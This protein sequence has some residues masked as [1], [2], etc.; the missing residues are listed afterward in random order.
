MINKLQAVILI[1]FLNFTVAHAQF[2]VR[3]YGAKGDGINLDTRSFQAAVDKAFNNGGGTVEVSPGTYLTGTVVLKDNVSVH[4]QPGS[5]ILGSA[6]YTDYT[7]IIHKYDSRTNGLYAKYFMFFAEGASNISITGEGIINGNGLKNFQK[8]DPQNLRPFMIRL[9]NCRDITIRDVKLLESANWTLHLLGCR[10]VNIEGIEINAGTRSNRDGIDIDACDRV[11]VSNCRITTGDDAIVMKTTNDTICQNIAITNCIISTQ[12]SGIKTGTESNGG[13][14]NITVSNCV[15]RDIPVHT[16]IELITVDGGSMQNILLENIT[17]ENVATPFFIRLGNRARPYKAGQY[18]TGV[19]DVS[20]IMLNNITVINSKLPSGIMGLHS[21]KLRN[22][23]VNNFTV[24]SSVAQKPVNY[25]EVPFEEFSYPAA[26]VFKNLPAYGLYCRNV[27][28]LQLNNIYFYSAENETR[29]ALVLD[30]V[31]NPGMFSVKG[32]VRD[33]E[34]PLAYFRYVA[35]AEINF[36]RSIGNSNSLFKKEENN[37]ENLALL[38]NTLNTGQKEIEVVPSPGKDSLFEDFPT[39]LKYI[40]S[41]SKAFKGLP[42]RDLQEEPLKFSMEINKRG[43]LQLC[44]LILDNT[45]KPGRVRVKYEGITQEFEISW[46]EWGW[47][48]L[49][50]LKEYPVDRKVDFEV[51]SAD[52]Q[53]DLKISRICFRYQDVRKTD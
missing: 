43:S 53:T 14:R 4:L 37:V 38:R 20:D 29:P 6:D 52:P 10:N 48:P 35:N 12:A 13:F 44:M 31:N 26:S 22:I 16:G 8:S 30:R 51:S 18:V 17:M 28:E 41:G 40:I 9:V 15:I 25:N 49:T 7:E 27:D 19:G 33:P 24:R 47:A 46:N 50:L 5:V 45:P 42:A 11:T 2:D 32:E 39:D 34:T 3:S 1:L 23:T 21:K 36:C